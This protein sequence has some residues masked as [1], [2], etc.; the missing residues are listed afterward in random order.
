MPLIDNSETLFNG[1]GYQIKYKYL[2]KRK[3]CLKPKIQ[4]M[5][6]YYGGGGARRG[7]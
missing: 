4:S 6:K 1:K 5:R 3:T 7:N 2:S